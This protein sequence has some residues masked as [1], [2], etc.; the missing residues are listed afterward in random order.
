MPVLA[1]ISSCESDD[2][3]RRRCTFS[4]ELSKID[5]H[6]T[7]VVEPLAEGLGLLIT[8]GSL[9]SKKDGRHPD[10]L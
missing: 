7:I 2:S 5:G 6:A 4:S 10:T 8:V 1:E 3:V 9:A